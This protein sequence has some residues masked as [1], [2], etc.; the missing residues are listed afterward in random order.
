MDSGINQPQ[1]DQKNHHDGGQP[2]GAAQG[3]GGFRLERHGFRELRDFA[4]PFSI[5]ALRTGKLRLIE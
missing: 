1:K 2:A 4:W 3:L 5:L